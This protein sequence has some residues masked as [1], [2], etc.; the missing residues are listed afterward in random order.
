MKFYRRLQPFK[1]ISFDLDDTLYSNAPVMEVTEAKMAVYFQDLLKVE[2]N[3][4][5]Y[6]FWFSYRQNVL[7]VQPELIH[8]VGALRQAGYAL[9]LEALGY[10]YHDAMHLAA[11]AQAYF[12]QC[13]SDFT[14][15]ASSHALLAEL[16]KKWPLVAISNG[17]AN[18]KS[19]NIDH[20]FSY[21][22]HAGN[23]LLHKP[24][25]DMFHRACEALNI[26]PHELL[27][28]GDCGVA[29]IAGANAA[30]CQAAYISTYNVGKPL[31]VLPHIAL[32]DVTQLHRLV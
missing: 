11:D 8:D 2:H 27:H 32:T 16:Q 1:A 10:S 15:P 4:Y 3:K 22:Y 6:N 18:T 31:R 7:A 14:V 28:V 24:L 5:D 12:N 17:N 29:D 20:Y 25:P 13:R 19:I 9:G 26:A 23:G 21:V 30:G